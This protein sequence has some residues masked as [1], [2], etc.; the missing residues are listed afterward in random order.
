MNIKK[1]IDSFLNSFKDENDIP[2]PPFK[3]SKKTASIMYGL[4]YGRLTVEEA[5]KK[6]KEWGFDEDRIEDIIAKS[7]K[8]P[9]FWS[10]EENKSK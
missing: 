6:A 4:W 2:P 5:R 8:P 10:R 3:A 1:Y 7:T 9:S